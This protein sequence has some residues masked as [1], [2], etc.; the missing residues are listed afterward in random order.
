MTLPSVEVHWLVPVKQVGLPQRQVQ[1]S[2]VV[3]LAGK[4]T[5]LPGWPGGLPVLP[6]LPEVPPVPLRVHLQ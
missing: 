2:R 3:Q 5:Q 4:A 6:P 1:S